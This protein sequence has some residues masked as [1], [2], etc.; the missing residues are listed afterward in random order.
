M[1][2]G[3][4]LAPTWIVASDSRGAAEDLPQE[5]GVLPAVLHEHILQG[6][7]PV[8]FIEDDGG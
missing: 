8:E 1:D 6:L 3:D 7:R 4:G 2:W 5:G